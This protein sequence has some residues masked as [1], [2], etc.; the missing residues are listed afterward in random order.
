MT[1]EMLHGLALGKRA[2]IV[3]VFVFIA[4]LKACT[5]NRMWV[6]KKRGNRIGRGDEIR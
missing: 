1:A 4:V 5:N 2:D 3:T 6:E